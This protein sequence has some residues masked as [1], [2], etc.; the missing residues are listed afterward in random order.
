[1]KRHAMLANA[2]I[3]ATTTLPG[4]DA[5][6]PLRWDFQLAPLIVA[7]RLDTRFRGYD[8]GGGTAKAAKPL[9]CQ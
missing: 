2:S 6:Q 4:F 1:M 3:Q 7:R 5:W 9:M 8:T